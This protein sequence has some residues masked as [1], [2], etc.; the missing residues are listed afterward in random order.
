MERNKKEQQKE[1]ERKRKE[2]EYKQKIEEKRKKDEQNEKLKYQEEQKKDE[3]EEKERKKQ[4][5]EREKKEEEFREKINRINEVE[6]K[7]FY[8]LSEN[9]IKDIME[10]INNPMTATW[11]GDD[12]DDRKGEHKIL[13]NER[14]YGYMVSLEIPFSC[15]KWHINRLMTLITV[16]SNNNNPKKMSK[17]DTVKKYADLNRQRRAAM[18]T[19]GAMQKCHTTRTRQKQ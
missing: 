2:E 4:L 14:I 9:N 1:L 3:Q 11:F 13:T 6:S 17:K 10:Y 8:G 12:G 18:H 16:C 7:V 19:K 5:I 15:E